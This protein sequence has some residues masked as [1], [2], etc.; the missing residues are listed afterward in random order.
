MWLW[1]TRF[2]S[3]SLFSHSQNVISFIYCSQPLSGWILSR[4]LNSSHCYVC[5]HTS[6]CGMHMML[7]Q[8]WCQMSC[9]H[10]NV[11]VLLCSLAN[12]PTE[13]TSVVCYYIFRQWQCFVPKCYIPAWLGSFMAITQYFWWVACTVVRSLWLAHLIS[14]RLRSMFKRINF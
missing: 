14:P 5:L 10:G 7:L 13:D 4:E 2:P 3:F 11:P 9:F 1:K 12:K 8:Q 6:V